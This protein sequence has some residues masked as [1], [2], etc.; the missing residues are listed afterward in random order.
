MEETVLVKLYKGEDIPEVNISEVWRYAGYAGIPDMSE[1]ELNQHLQDVIAKA[2]KELTYKVVYLRTERLPIEHDSVELSKLL[3]D[4][5]E[6][7]MFAATIGLGIDR[8][9][10]LNEK[11]S[12]VKALL[13]Q[14]LGAERVE[15][16]CD[17]FCSEIEQEVSKEG[18]T[19]TMRFSPGYGDFP[20]EKQQE[21]F[22]IL[23]CNRKIGI[24]L[25]SSMLMTPSKSVTAVFGVKE[26]NDDRDRKDWCAH[27][28]S[29]CPNVNC[30][31]RM[32]TSH[33]KE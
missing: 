3:T 22:R 8:L 20:L 19:L 13:L 6:V 11:I 10:A 25:N 1:A 14:A 27:K 23:D 32:K 30:E 2:E 5:S 15:A 17:K 24:S 26:G 21:F 31:Y 18:K 28:C 12:P 4:C 7:C 16:L 29:S 9:I 33:E